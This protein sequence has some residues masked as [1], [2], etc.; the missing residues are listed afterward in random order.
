MTNR[1]FPSRPSTRV[2]ILGLNVGLFMSPLNSQ[3]AP[4]GDLWGRMYGA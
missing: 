3:L 2:K 1:A 4:L